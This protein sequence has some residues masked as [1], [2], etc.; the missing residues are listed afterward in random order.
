[1]ESFS[2]FEL[3]LKKKKA[4]DKSFNKKI[5]NCHQKKTPKPFDPLEPNSLSHKYEKNSLAE[6]TNVNKTRMKKLTTNNFLKLK[7]KLKRKLNQ[8]TNNSG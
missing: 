8:S 7:K 3:N 2:F 5:L 6:D 4:K 1:M